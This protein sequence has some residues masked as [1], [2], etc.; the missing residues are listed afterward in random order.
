VLTYVNV[1]V[2]LFLGWLLLDEVITG[3]M[4]LATAFIVS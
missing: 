4:I 2:A 1:V 3:K